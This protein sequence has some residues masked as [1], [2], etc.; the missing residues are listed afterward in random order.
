V[1]TTAN[2]IAITRYQTT[3]VDFDEAGGWGCHVG[4]DVSWFFTGVVGVGGFGRYAPGTVDYADPFTDERRDL[5]VGGFQGG[6]G[7]RLRF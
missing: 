3:Q 5:K 1:I 4:A 7:L 2:A 6:G